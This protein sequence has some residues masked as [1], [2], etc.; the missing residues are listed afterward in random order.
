MN[1]NLENK[2]EKKLCIDCKH[3]QYYI[4][5]EYGSN[6]YCYHPNNL[7]YVNNSPV[8]KPEHHRDPSNNPD[9]L[10]GIEG[11]WFE[12]KPKPPELPTIQKK[13]FWV[14]LRESFQVTRY[15]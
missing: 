14:K 4:S 13:S 5:Y 15:W 10:C 7:N 8:W 1:N 12:L 9:C 11:K 3:Y 6:H 2:P